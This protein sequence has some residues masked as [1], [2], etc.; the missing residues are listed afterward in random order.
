MHKSNTNPEAVR[1]EALTP[2]ECR[3]L[4]DMCWALQSAEVLAHYRGEFV[5]PYMQRVV[6]HGDDELA[7]LAEAARVTGREIEELSVVGITDPLQ[8]ASSY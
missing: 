5:V 3:R 2:E 8:D 7:V 1:V 4:Q 6:A